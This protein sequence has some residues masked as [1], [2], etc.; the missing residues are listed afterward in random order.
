MFFSCFSESYGTHHLVTAPFF[1]LGDEFLSTM[2]RGVVEDIPGANPRHP[3]M[4][5]TA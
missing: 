4:D 1:D 5:G 2:P 3:K